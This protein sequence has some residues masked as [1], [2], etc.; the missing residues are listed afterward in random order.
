MAR[1][2]RLYDLIRRLRD[3]RVHRA[4]D[5]ARRLGVSERTLYRDMDTLMA[6]GI[7]V[8]GTRGQG[9]RMTRPV[10]LPPMALT[11]TELEALHLGLAVVAEGAD[12]D[13]GRA[14]RDLAA[15]LEAALPENAPPRETG[16]ALAVYPFAD[17]A[18]ALK[19]LPRIRPALRSRQKLALT[20]TDGAGQ[21]RS[22]TVRPLKLDY[23]GRVW[24]LG[25]WSDTASAFADIRVDQ[26]SELRVLPALFVDEPGKSVSD[27]ERRSD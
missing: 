24:S 10:T 17:S 6:S 27:F 20:W 1:S 26:I 19:H 13:M 3:G 12:D 14:A 18:A 11:Q 16:G 9:Y 5:L 23:W 15:R 25:V 8:E 21:R 4:G 2:D 7:P 22:E